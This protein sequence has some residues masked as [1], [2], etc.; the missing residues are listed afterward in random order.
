MGFS[1]GLFPKPHIPLYNW[2]E[3]GK[4]KS[5]LL[6]TMRHISFS[7]YIPSADGAY[8]LN[9]KSGEWDLEL[10]EKSNPTDMPTNEHL[11]KRVEEDN[12]PEK[13]K[14][15][16]EISETT[17]DEVPDDEIDL[18]QAT[19]TE[20][21]TLHGMDEELAVE[22]LDYLKNNNIKS[23]DELLEIE[24]IDRQTLKVWAKSLSQK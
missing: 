21:M 12:L 7:K 24:G 4:I 20:L 22:V 5:S 8:Y 11:L 15:D 2:E 6:R 16:S 1:D 9:D 13:I 14:S 18:N 10:T 23:I 19:L 17:Q 3:L